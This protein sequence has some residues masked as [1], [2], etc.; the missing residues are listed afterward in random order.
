MTK[1]NQNYRGITGCKIKYKTKYIGSN[2]LWCQ[3]K[4]PTAFTQILDEAGSSKPAM[5]MLHKR[6]E[7]NIRACEYI[8][9]RK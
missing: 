9:N 7:C 4:R 1:A 6:L 5:Q 8:D 3:K 2:P